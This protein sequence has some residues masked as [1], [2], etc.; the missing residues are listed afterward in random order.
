MTD[1]VEMTASLRRLMATCSKSLTS[2]SANQSIA[3]IH[4]RLLVV[5]AHV[6]E[7]TALAEKIK[8]LK[9]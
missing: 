2:L 9:N 1:K 8:N 5:E 7:A 6:Q 3:D 4:T